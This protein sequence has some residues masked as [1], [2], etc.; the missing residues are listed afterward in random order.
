VKRTKKRKAEALIKRLAQLLCIPVEVTASERG[1]RL[2]RHCAAK[3]KL[4]GFQVIDCSSKGKPYDLIVNGFRVQCKNRNKHGNSANGVNLFKNSQKRYKAS[5]VDFFVIR[6][7][8]KCFVIPT[9]AISDDKGSV[10]GYVTLT[11]K[12]HFIDAWHQ[13][14]GD[15]IYAE[16]QMNLFAR[17][18]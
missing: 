5:D 11:N 8:R 1:R 2:E 18:C 17:S 12:K 14:G 9:A 10:I 6:F 15:P 13:L 7:S 16:T 4:L 3:F